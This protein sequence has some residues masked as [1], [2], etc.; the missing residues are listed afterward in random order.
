MHRTARTRQAVNA[1]RKRGAVL[2]V[3]VFLA[4]GLVPGFS[5]GCHAVLVL[6][7]HMTGHPLAPGLLSGG[8]VAAGGMVG[9]ITAASISIMAGWYGGGVLASVAATV[10]QLL[11]D[12][13]EQQ[14]RARRGM[15]VLPHT[16]MAESAK[17]ELRSRI[18]FLRD[19]RGMVHSIVAVGSAAHGAE[20]SGSDIDIVIICRKDGIEAV[21]SAVA[22]Q[23]LDEALGSGSG[24]AL[25]ITVID[26]GEAEK[27]FGLGSP[28]SFAL[29]RGVVLEDDGCLGSLL[30]R[31][32]LAPGRKYALGA[33]FQNIMVLYYGS[34]R[35]LHRSA[36]ANNCSS[37]CCRER[38]SGCAGIAAADVPVTVLMRML[39][40]TLPL[41]GCMPLT[42]QDVTAFTRMEYGDESA[43]AVQRAVE[44]SRSDEKRIFYTDYL[45][46]KR[47][48]GMLY[49]EVLAAVGTGRAVSRM[50]HDGACMAQGRYGQLKDRDLRRCVQ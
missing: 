25:E 47:L 46:F 33:L 34:F 6:F 44:L 30:G 10:G 24:R 40:V 20:T 41:R 29:G 35:S 45:M 31:S 13:H 26:P 27:L 1:G 18:S 14:E 39:Y 12:H 9:A 19:C 2:G 28:F 15:R 42:K 22:G 49:R 4:M 16:R 17:E 48:A 7:A 11:H 5:L 43:E 23:E 3:L 8:L 50:L 37:E 36:K 21:Q 32:F 38:R